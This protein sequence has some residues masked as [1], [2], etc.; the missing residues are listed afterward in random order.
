MALP[1]AQMSVT[2][3]REQDLR[4]AL[5]QVRDAIDRYKSA[6]D[7]GRIAKAIGDSGYPPNLDTLVSGVADRTEASGKK[8]Y[9]LRAIP[10]DPFCDCKELDNAATWG[11]RSYASPPDRPAPGKDVFDIYSRAPGNGI[12]GIPYHDW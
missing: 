9:F 2:R 5:W 8:I 3:S 1:L 10:R 7:S 12:N 11:L 6:S 4:R